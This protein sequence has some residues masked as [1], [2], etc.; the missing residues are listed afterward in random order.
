MLYTLEE[1][2]RMDRLLAVFDDYAAASVDSDVAYS[3]KSGYV[4]LIIA[5]H[6]DAVF[7]Q[8]EDFDDMLNMFFFDIF[9]EEV[10]LARE[11]HSH[12]TGATMDFSGFELRLRTRLDVLGAD[13][14]YALGELEKF[15][16]YWKK[17][18]RLP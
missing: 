18:P 9:C 8:I 4:R 2:L 17:S 1:K 14:E 10:S 7:F 11:Q 6:A 15:I 5:D 12:L 16:G 13:R 3:E